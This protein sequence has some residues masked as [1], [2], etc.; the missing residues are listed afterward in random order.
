MEYAATA[1]TVTNNQMAQILTN[2]SNFAELPKRVNAFC[3]L[4]PWRD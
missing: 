3:G 4:V 1:P 2:L